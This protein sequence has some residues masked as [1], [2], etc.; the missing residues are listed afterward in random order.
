MSICTPTKQARYAALLATSVMVLGLSAAASRAQ[1]GGPPDAAPVEYQNG[2]NEEVVI[3]APRY[4]VRRSAIGAPIEDVAMSRE[5]R[6][7]DLDLRTHRGAR[8]LKARIRE[9]AR[10]LCDRMDVRYPIAT[11]D[12]PPCYETAV[13][14]AL[15]EADDAIADARG[16]ARAD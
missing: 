13:K 1:D 2:P 9:T 16:Y 4:H 14:T 5:V 11:E 7:D 6:F 15:Y 3:T 8:I 10:A 12:S